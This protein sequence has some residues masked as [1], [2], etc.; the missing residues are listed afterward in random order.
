MDSETKELH[1][2]LWNASGINRIALNL[3]CLFGAIWGITLYFAFQRLKNSNIGLLYLFSIVIVSIIVFFKRFGDLNIDLHDAQMIRLF[4]FI[5]MAIW[6]SGWIHANVILSKYMRLGQ[7]RLKEL[8]ELPK[9]E[10]TMNL[11]MER[12]LIL[13]KVLS[14]KNTALEDFKHALQFSGG[15][16]YVLSFIADHLLYDKNYSLAKQYFERAL[17]DTKNDDLL[18]HINKVLPYVKKK[19]DKQFIG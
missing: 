12:G 6:I 15:E 17:S 4:G 16:G 14:K 10:L 18:K 9:D 2:F 11:L 19:A 13:N 8:N 3:Y 5:N 1:S 7:V